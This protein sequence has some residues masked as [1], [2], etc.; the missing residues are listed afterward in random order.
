MS[1]VKM[2]AFVVA[3]LVA[4]CAQNA[5][6][7]LDNQ[8]LCVGNGQGRGVPNL[9]KMPQCSV[10]QTKQYQ[11]TRQIAQWQILHL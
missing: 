8:F 11:G 1:P 6:I 3:A 2:V 7:T 4:L 10:R 5:T 9:K